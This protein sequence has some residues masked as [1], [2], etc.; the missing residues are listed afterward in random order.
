MAARW[1]PPAGLLLLLLLAV[2]LPARADR[3]ARTAHADDDPEASSAVFQLYGNVYPHGLYYVAMSI[4]NP[5]KPYF[6]D[7]DTGSDLTWLQC[8]APCVS[9]SKVG[10]PFPF[11]PYLSNPVCCH[12]TPDLAQGT[13]TLSLLVVPGPRVAV[14][15]I[16][17]P[18]YYFGTESWS[19]IHSLHTHIHGYNE[20]SGN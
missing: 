5:A 19:L 1:A 10:V 3:P 20:F 4:G 7:V 9:C 8:D 18:S 2:L 6:L 11:L 17:G 12:W 14:Q 13:E 16:R 15:G